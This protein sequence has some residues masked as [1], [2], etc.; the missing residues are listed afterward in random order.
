[1]NDNIALYAA[2]VTLIGNLVVLITQIFKLTKVNNKL[3]HSIHVDRVADLKRALEFPL[4]GVW[5]VKGTFKPYHGVNEEHRSSGFII[6]TWNEENGNYFVK[7]AYSAQKSNA[8]EDLVT[9]LCSGSATYITKCGKPEIK[10]DMNIEGRTA[11]DRSIPNF[12]HFKLVSS[13]ISTDK[14]SKKVNDIIFP[15]NSP[16]S[17]GE[18]HIT[19]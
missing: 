7:Y 6:F 1:M 2:L 18:I 9:A 10:L 4:E 3:S 8:S 17:N 12:R 5:S 11:S 16:Q 15:F 13:K 19:R 14:A